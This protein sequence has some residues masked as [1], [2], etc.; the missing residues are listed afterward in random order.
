MVQSRRHLLWTAGLGLWLAGPA[1]A[2][3]EASL[4]NADVGNFIFSL[5][6]FGLVVAILGRFAWKPLLTVLNAR[7]KS[8]REAL[9]AARQERE[10]AALL[11]KQYQE[12][13]A[14]AREQAAAIVEEGRRD[15]EAV[16]QRIQA[17]ARQQAEEMLARARREIQLATEVALKELFDRTAE[18]AVQVA[19]RVLRK[20]LSSQV[21]SELIAESLAEIEKAA[22]SRLN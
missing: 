18:L 7:E 1:M 16:R 19:G 9:E 8:I 17:E 22:T 12:Q 4:F 5:L 2:G 14:R 13:L 6:V 21:H 3:Q 10:A 20:G 15:G 11:L